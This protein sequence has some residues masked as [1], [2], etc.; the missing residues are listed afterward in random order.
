MAWLE[1]VL[2]R[3]WRFPLSFLNDMSISARC[4]GGSMLVS[5]LSGPRLCRE[6]LGQWFRPW[7]A[8]D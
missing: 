5:A 7:L 8:K 2:I 4:S 6:P 1:L 3:Q